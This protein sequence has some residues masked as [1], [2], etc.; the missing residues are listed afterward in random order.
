M[1]AGKHFA[2]RARSRGFVRTTVVA[3]A[4]ATAFSWVS[5]AGAA[6]P[7]SRDRRLA[8]SAVRSSVRL[9][10]LWGAQTRSFNNSGFQRLFELSFPAYLRGGSVPPIVDE[11]APVSEICDG[12]RLDV[13]HASAATLSRQLFVPRFVANQM[14]DRRPYIDVAEFTHKWGLAAG[15]AF[16]DPANLCVTPTSLPPAAPN[17]CAKDSQVDINDPHGKGRLLRYFP[18]PLASWIV[19]GQ[20]YLKLDNLDRV[21]G[22]YPLSA[23]VRKNLCVTPPN[24]DV[25]D[26]TRYGWIDSSDG[27]DLRLLKFGLDVPD[28]TLEHPV[29]AWASI[30]PVVSPTEVEAPSIPSAD[31]HIY[32]LWQDG[33]KTVRVTLPFDPAMEKFGSEF[34]PTLAHWDQPERQTGE[35]LYE[36]EVD[37]NANDE[38]VSADVD[39][40]SIFDSLTRVPT[41]LFENVAGF[42]TGT[43]FGGPNCDSHWSKQDSGDWTRNGQRVRL[44]GEFLDLPG[45]IVP[46]FG[47]PIKHCVAARVDNQKPITSDA[48]LRLRNNT[49]T[50][51]RVFDHSG[52]GQVGTVNFAPSFDWLWARAWTEVSGEVYAYPG[53]DV[54]LTVPVGQAATVH[55]KPA[56]FQTIAWKFI[57]ELPVA[58]VID[59]LGALGVIDAIRECAVAEFDNVVEDSSAIAI[60]NFVRDFGAHCIPMDLIK[61]TLESQLGQGNLTRPKFNELDENLQQTTRFLKVLKVADFGITAF[62]LSS[63]LYSGRIKLD[64]YAARPSVD[65]R[66]RKLFDACV[67]LVGLNWVIDEACQDRQ[68]TGLNQVQDG[69][70]GSAP[71][72]PV[73]RLARDKDGT[74]WL[75]DQESNVARHVTNPGVYLCLAKHYFV[76][77][78]V[79]DLNSYL[80]PNGANTFSSA[81]VTCSDSTDTRNLRQFMP[82]THVLRQDDAQGTSWVISDGVRYHIENG[83]QFTCWVSPQGSPGFP[84]HNERHV[85][86]QVPASTV[87]QWATSEFKLAGCGAL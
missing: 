47:F 44:A 68:Y 7:S 62:D 66:G 14:V 87:L 3:V 83:A 46:I 12:G 31:F 54:T 10:G 74:V 84:F 23:M 79:D 27:G 24:I 39:S 64:H 11:L 75:I 1:S 6:T 55:M 65:S 33:H 20:P 26:G 56:F 28:N 5:P 72:F 49:G 37:I 40:L 61:K 29:G 34:I 50:M 38:T 60:A 8:T 70:G 25:A 41:W 32:G 30:K 69:S 57:K 18:D 51:Q 19:A 58:Y 59:Q 22:T 78:D 71:E 2:P 43:R 52:S 53:G 48:T 85:W 86:D 15:N 36:D 63:T 81:P 16:F 42:L 4:V 9:A 21:L 80:L 45:A 13:N 73:G 17:P 82:G 77:W 76:D 35:E 67:A